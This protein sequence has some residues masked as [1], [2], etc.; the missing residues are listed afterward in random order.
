MQDVSENIES[1]FIA[2]EGPGELHQ[3]MT[4]FVGRSFIWDSPA[5]W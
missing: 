5:L 2:Y 4:P 3:P 1:V